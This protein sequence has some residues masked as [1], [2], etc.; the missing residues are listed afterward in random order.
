MISQSYSWHN[1]KR[2]R[3]FA[4]CFIESVASIVTTD[5]ILILY[6]SEFW[7]DESRDLLRT[8]L[9]TGVSHRLQQSHKSPDTNGR[10]DCGR[11]ST[12]H[13]LGRSGV[14]NDA[15]D[16]HHTAHKQPTGPAPWTSIEYDLIDMHWIQICYSEY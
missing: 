1:L 15:D 12:Q 13:N 9:R 16:H 8:I 4:V 5:K 10:D 7:P 3:V 6:D 11:E 2:G 14:A